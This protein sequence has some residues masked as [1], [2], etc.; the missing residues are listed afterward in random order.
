MSREIGLRLLVAAQLFGGVVVAAMY[1]HLCA[2]V[3]E[4]KKSIRAL[5]RPPT[6]T[7]YHTHHTEEPHQ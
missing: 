6:V 1:V 4:L 2:E 3:D 7:L 5:T